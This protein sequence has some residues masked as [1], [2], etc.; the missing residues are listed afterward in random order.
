[1][2][3]QNSL[4]PK[5][6]LVGGN[7]TPGCFR[8]GPEVI[9]PEPEFLPDP[10]LE[11]NPNNEELKNLLRTMAFMDRQI[12]KKD[13]YLFALQMAKI[14][15]ELPDY[16]RNWA[17]DKFI[18]QF[19]NFYQSLPLATHQLQF[20][21][22]DPEFGLKYFVLKPRIETDAWILSI[23]GT[24]TITDWAADSALGGSLVSQLST[25]LSRCVFQRANGQ[26]AWDRRLV[27]VGHSLGGGMAQVLGY[28]IAKKVSKALPEG[29]P[30]PIEVVTWNAFGARETLE[31][32][33]LWEEG[34]AQKFTTANYFVTGDLVSRIGT[35]IGLTYEIPNPDGLGFA[36]AHIMEN[37]EKFVAI[38]PLALFSAPPRRPPF[39]EGI[40]GLSEVVGSVL[41]PFRGASYIIRMHKIH[42]SLA[43]SLALT[44][45]QD[46][47]EARTQALYGYLQQITRDEMTR[48]KAAGKTIYADSLSRHFVQADRRI[49]RRP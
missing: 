15:Y 47:K 5:R 10:R 11:Q 25:I 48:L 35:H 20:A 37:V 7:G 34:L 23:A 41:G 2:F 13:R 46:I 17:A 21:Y 33:K 4:D 22:S 42:E 18:E 12:K 49:Y 1:M 45:E 27:I 26:L 36:K 14:V 29:L 38:N 28:Q 9:P 40:T 44:A 6:I 8:V 39:K 32:A 3:A 30:F 24:Q 43:Q 19:N 16:E 31:R